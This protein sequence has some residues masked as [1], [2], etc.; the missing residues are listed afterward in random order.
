MFSVHDLRINSA[1][2]DCVPNLKRWIHNRPIIKV[3]VIY[4]LSHLHM[5]IRSSKKKKHKSSNKCLLSFDMVIHMVWESVK[6]ISCTAAYFAYTTLYKHSVIPIRVNEPCA[7]YM[8][9]Y[10]IW[11]LS[12]ILIMKGLRYCNVFTVKQYNHSQTLRKNMS[13]T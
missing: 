7:K 3:Q 5:G 2:L 13:Q 10:L 1:Q 9:V 12:I 11:S 6:T 8:I 4:N